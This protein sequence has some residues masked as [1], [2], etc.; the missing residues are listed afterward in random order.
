MTVK[1]NKHSHGN[2]LFYVIV[3]YVME[4]REG[5]ERERM[6]CHLIFLFRKTDVCSTH[7]SGYLVLPESQGGNEIISTALYEGRPHTVFQQTF[8]F[9]PKRIKSS[10]VVKDCCSFFHLESLYS[11][12]LWL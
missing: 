7:Q 5:Q 9:F 12:R 1:E 8:F 3:Y 6:Q 11:G 4:R 10:C 2:R